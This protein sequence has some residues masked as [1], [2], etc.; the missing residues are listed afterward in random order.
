MKLNNL[1]VTAMMFSVLAISAIRY[2]PPKP[3]VVCA[4]PPGVICMDKPC[5]F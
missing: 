1:V 4:C 5:L 3:P 2:I